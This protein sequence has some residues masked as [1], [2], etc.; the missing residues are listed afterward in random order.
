MVNQEN[1][2][3][4]FARYLSGN[5]PSDEEKELFIWIEEN[6]SNK[7]E[8]LAYK[9]VWS[10][11]DD[12]VEVNKQKAWAKI[13]NTIVHQDRGG[14]VIAFFSGSWMRI[15]ATLSLAL[16]STMVLWRVFFYERGNNLQSLVALENVEEFQ[17]DD[18]STVSLRKNSTLTFP[19]EF[20]S[21]ER[22]VKLN[23]TGFFEVSKDKDRPF[24]VQTDYG[25]IK[26]L[27]TSFLVETDTVGEITLVYVDSGIVFVFPNDDPAKGIELTLKGAAEISHGQVRKIQ[28]GNTN[29]IAWKSKKIRFKNES[30]ENVFNEIGKIYGIKIH[31]QNESFERCQFTGKFSGAEIEV[32]LE[33]LAEIY[34]FEYLIEG[35]EVKI[36]GGDC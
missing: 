30:L 7:N 28:L 24:F 15:A 25:T 17:L 13:K 33:E 31:Y 19:E 18:L 23:G 20:S 2:E 1:K 32:I 26:V 6:E 12:P 9:M 21:E 35:N 10:L 3:D 34:G 5:L 29:I 4:L 14:R 22:I 36:A 11:I 8:F 16:V 27:G